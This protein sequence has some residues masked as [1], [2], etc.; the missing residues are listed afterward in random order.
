MH[1]A[2][3]SVFARHVT[4]LAV[5][6]H[7]VEEDLN[8]SLF[9]G[10]PVV[11]AHGI[12]AAGAH[13]RENKDSEQSLLVCNM[14]KGILKPPHAS[15]SFSDMLQSCESK[16]SSHVQFLHFSLGAVVLPLSWCQCCLVPHLADENLAAV[17]FP[18]AKVFQSQL[19]TNLLFSQ[20]TPEAVIPTVVLLPPTPGMALSEL[21]AAAGLT[22][23][24]QPGMQESSQLLLEPPEQ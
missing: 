14:E 12:G 1:C 18:L 8:K 21:L 4:K 6:C 7:C 19:L 24:S 17:H 3:A 9:H 16:A 23:H 2:A 10:Q 22:E 13:R 5:L 20:V 15:D 11:P